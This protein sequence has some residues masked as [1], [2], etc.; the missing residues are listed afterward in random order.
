MPNQVSIAG[1]SYSALT[2]AVGATGSW[3]NND[4]M[5]HTATS[6]AGSAFAFDTGTIGGG[7]TGVG[8]TFSRGGTFPYHCEFHSGMHGSI[9]VQ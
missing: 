8:I 1:L 2:V 6:D 7:E 5:S 9:T 4:S 3:K